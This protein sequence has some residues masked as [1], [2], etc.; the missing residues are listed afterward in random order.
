LQRRKHPDEVSQQL[1]SLV[2]RILYQFLH[3]YKSKWKK[4]SLQ[5]E[6]IKWVATTSIPLGVFI[7]FFLGNFCKLV[8]LAGMGMIKSNGGI[9][10]RKLGNS[11]K[12]VGWLLL[13]VST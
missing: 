7:P 8:A 11:C 3:G 13:G 5:H 4:T 9:N 10:G 6:D 12:S 2:R 1:V